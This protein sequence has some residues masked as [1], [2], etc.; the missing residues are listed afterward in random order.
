MNRRLLTVVA[1]IAAAI[2]GAGIMLQARA[3]GGDQGLAK[4]P[5]AVRESVKKLVGP[6]KMSGFGVEKTLGLTIFV[7]EVEAK[8]GREYAFGLNAE[9]KIIVRWVGIDPSIVPAEVIAAAKK[10]HPNG[11]I[12]ETTIC[13]ARNKLSYSLENKVG[14]DTY[15]MMFD[16]DGTVTYNEIKRGGAEGDAEKK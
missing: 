2:T 4:A 14:N 5:K 6:N 11:K 16:P 9:G 1:L 13:M 3:G 15:Q 7:V 12:G 8:N 10:A